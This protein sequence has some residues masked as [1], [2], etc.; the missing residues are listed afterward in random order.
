MN[1]FEKISLIISMIALSLQFVSF[2]LEIQDFKQNNFEEI[3][4]VEIK[5]IND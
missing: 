2:G 1:H 3:A 5:K 4:I